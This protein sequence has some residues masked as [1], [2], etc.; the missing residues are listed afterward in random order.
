MK[1]KENLSKANSKKKIAIICGSMGVGGGETIAAR[2]CT[3]INSNDFE[4]KLFIIGEYE[5]N[6][7]AKMLKDNVVQY[8]CIGAKSGFSLKHYKIFSKAMREFKPDV[9]HSH[10]DSTY[11]WIWS[12]LH[13]KPLIFT[14]HSNPFRWKDKRVQFLI[15]LK[16]LQGKLKIIGCAKIIA[17]YAKKCY[18]IS[19][20]KIGYIYNP[21]E[22]ENYQKGAKFDGN[23]KF[24]Y[25]G[26]FNKVKNQK[27]L[28]SAFS[29]LEKTYSNVQLSLA[30]TGPR[31]DEIQNLAKE[32]G[33]RN[34]EFLGNVSDIP[35][36]L[37]KNDVLV[38]SS[39][40]EAC[41][42]VVLEAMAS[43]LPI[44]ATN[45]GGVP[46]LVTDN[47]FV[48]EKGDV[49]AFT[50]AMAKIV[51]DFENAK[52]MGNKSLEYAKQYDKDV[53]TR[54][55]EQEYLKFVKVEK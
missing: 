8:T 15:K 49:G 13:C 51:D 9:V 39:D 3:Y 6:Q 12:L 38:L 26:R 19:S 18:K 46:E 35:G 11:S 54:A 55:Y 42:V 24:A 52:I 21:I 40:S 22:I 41:P 14:L 45:V 28:I 7:I 17:E 5:D 37:A 31:F 53:V 20:K 47:G 30:G 2:L 25:V 44:I 34:I 16:S 29:E 32:K 4:V 48:V 23:V 33:C 36:F 50:E 43:G 10:L 1:R 27:L